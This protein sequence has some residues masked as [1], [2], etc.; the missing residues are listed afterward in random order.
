MTRT[1]IVAMCRKYD[2]ALEV[3]AL[4]SLSLQRVSPSLGMGTPCSRTSF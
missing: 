3:R 2:I 4:Y 1:D